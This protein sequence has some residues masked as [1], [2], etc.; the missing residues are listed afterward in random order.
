VPGE[1]DRRLR[2]NAG[3]SGFDTASAVMM[4]M[5]TRASA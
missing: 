3:A 1:L 4:Q 2:R 5:C